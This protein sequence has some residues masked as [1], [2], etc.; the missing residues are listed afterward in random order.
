MPGKAAFRSTGLKALVR[1]A[2]AARVFMP[3]RP[4]GRALFPPIGVS[5]GRQ[6]LKA[7]ATYAALI[8]QKKSLRYC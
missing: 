7:L 2:N 5:A 6:G 4:T 3:P 8:R 1:K